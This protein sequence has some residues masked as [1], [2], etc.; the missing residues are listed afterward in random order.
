MTDKDL[1]IFRETLETIRLTGMV[2]GDIAIH[3]PWPEQ[4]NAV[5]EYFGEASVIT[6]QEW[7]ISMVSY[8]SKLDLLIMN[9]VMM[10]ISNPLTT[11]CNVLKSCNYLLIQDIISRD[12]GNNEILGGDGDAMRY[13]FPPV[14]SNFKKALDLNILKNQIIFLYPYT[15]NHVNIHFIALMKGI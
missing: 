2:S 11:F 5:T 8:P 4:I 12:R 14:K 1:D 10:Y 3:S 6:R 15:D 7:D 13:C 9:N